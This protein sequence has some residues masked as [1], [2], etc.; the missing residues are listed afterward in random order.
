MITTHTLP[1]QQS[2]GHPPSQRVPDTEAGFTRRCGKRDPVDKSPC[3]YE[4]GHAGRHAWE[5]LTAGFG[6]GRG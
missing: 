1:T 4:Y 3:M 6:V 2:Q 5:P